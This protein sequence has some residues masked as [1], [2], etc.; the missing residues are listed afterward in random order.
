MLQTSLPSKYLLWV[1]KQL[2]DFQIVPLSD[3]FAG[4]FD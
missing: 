2:I 1:R 3:N 4:F